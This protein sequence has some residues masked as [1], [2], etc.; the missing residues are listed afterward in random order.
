MA[1]T[2]LNKY[3]KKNDKEHILD[4]PDTYVGSVEKVDAD[5]FIYDSNNIVK[6]NITYIPGLYKLF[7]EA[8]VNCRDQSV[9]MEQAIKN[10]EDN[11]HPLTYIDVSID[12]E[13]VITM[14]NDGNGID[15]AEHPEYKIWIPEMIFAHLRTSTNY[16]QSFQLYPKLTK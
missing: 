9:R 4:N 5:E 3:Q 1:S 12:D 8:I 7:D 14:T 6:K 2:D 15:I 16:D 10:K 13:G 11:I